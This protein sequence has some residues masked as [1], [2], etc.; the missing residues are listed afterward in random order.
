M[1]ALRGEGFAWKNTVLVLLLPVSPGVHSAGT[2]VRATLPARPL[3]SFP[4]AAVM[5]GYQ[6]SGL[7]QHTFV[8]LLFFRSEVLWAESPRCVQA[9]FP[10]EAFGDD[11]FPRLCQ[12]SQAACIPWLH[13]QSQ[14]RVFSSSLCP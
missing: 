6:L 4:V 13:L 9:W 1:E 8:V 10:R 5:H 14:R 11:A 2:T 7:N 12:H 3:N